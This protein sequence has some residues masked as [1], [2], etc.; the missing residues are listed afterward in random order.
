V[1]RRDAAGGAFQAGAVLAAA[2][3]LYILSGRRPRT[4]LPDTPMRWL[5][6]IGLGVFLW[7]PSA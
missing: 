1:G 5:V 3:V 6:V 4:R 2:S 7:W